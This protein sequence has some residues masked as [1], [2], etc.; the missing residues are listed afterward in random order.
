VFTKRESYRKFLEEHEENKRKIEVILDHV[1]STI[2]SMKEFK[3]SNYVY[4]KDSEEHLLEIYFLEVD[5]VLKVCTINIF[6][7]S[8]VGYTIKDAHRD[9]FVK[10]IESRIK[11]IKKHQ[12]KELKRS[13]F[14]QKIG[15]KSASNSADIQYLGLK[16]SLELSEKL[17][18]Y[19]SDKNEIVYELVGKIQE[20]INNHV[21]YPYMHLNRSFEEV[22]VRVSK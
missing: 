15:L 22:K 21:S 11:F 16:Q 13:K 20:E 18:E 3:D 12:G 9:S 2:F 8:I 19:I 6:D 14:F 17:L 4:F 1:A 7:Q 5:S 10:R